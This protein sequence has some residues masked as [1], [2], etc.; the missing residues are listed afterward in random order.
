MS[1]SSCRLCQLTPFRAA[2][3]PA[4]ESV[5]FTDFQPCFAV[6]DSITAWKQIMLHTCRRCPDLRLLKFSLKAPAY[7]DEMNKKEKQALARFPKELEALVKWVS[8]FGCAPVNAPPQARI[9][10]MSK[11]PPHGRFELCFD[12]DDNREAKVKIGASLLKLRL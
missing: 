6:F 5:D 11:L 12:I 1:A 7:F 2:P 10:V 4:V 9:Q 8:G 3:A